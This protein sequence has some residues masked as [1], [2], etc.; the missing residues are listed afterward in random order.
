[1]MAE[2][3]AS[4]ETSFSV[5]PPVPRR[6]ALPEGVCWLKKGLRGKDSKC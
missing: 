5:M 1:V 2:T 6:D 4:L 3:P